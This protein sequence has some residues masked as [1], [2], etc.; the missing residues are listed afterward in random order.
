GS[1][2]FGD[3][4]YGMVYSLQIDDGEFGGV[5]IRA[6]EW[7]DTID[8]TAPNVSFDNLNMIASTAS[9]HSYLYNGVPQMEYFIPSVEVS[10]NQKYLFCVYT[11]SEKV[12]IGYDNAVDYTATMN[13]NLKP[14]A[15][16]RIKPFSSLE[17]WI[18]TGFGND[19]G[20]PA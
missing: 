10:A 11:E 1:N 18:W 20:V 3:D 7:N 4:V 8:I 16:I 9:F 13:L 19:K 12:K 17:E 14:I 5:E 6:Y 2:G 15:P